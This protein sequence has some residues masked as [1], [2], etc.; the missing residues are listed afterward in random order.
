MVFAVLLGTAAPR[1]AFASAPWSADCSGVASSQQ[2]CAYKGTQWT[3]NVAHMS[4]DNLSYQDQTWPSS[5]DWLEDTISST[6]NLYNNQQVRWYEGR[7]YGG[8]A[9]ACND[10][11]SG[12]YTL[13]FY[14]NDK[15]SS[16]DVTSGTC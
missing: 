15:F 8:P 12:F 2:V 7:N 13:S 3:S 1:I 14:F 6:K 11:N 4:G 5:S 9:Y 16:H 10:V